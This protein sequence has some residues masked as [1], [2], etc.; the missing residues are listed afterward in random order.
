MDRRVFFR[1][2]FYGVWSYSRF[3]LFR[4]DY[5]VVLDDIALIFC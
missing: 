4:L 1:F 5:K 2:V 3:L